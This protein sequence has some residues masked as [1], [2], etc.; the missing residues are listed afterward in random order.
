MVKTQSETP[1]PD[2]APVAPFY[3]RVS[4]IIRD[5]AE[6]SD[7]PQVEINELDGSEI[8]VHDVMFLRGEYERSDPDYAII[9]FGGAT[10]GIA[11][12]R[13]NGHPVPVNARTTSCGGSVF[14]R[15]LKMLSGYG[16]EDAP[17]QL[18]ILGRVVRR[19]SKAA[20]KP[21]PYYDFA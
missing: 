14:V 11:P 3:K 21:Q 7:I 13:L 6:W 1:E 20:G 15:K 12:E 16:D 9:L 5:P 8:V 18:P 2:A 19:Q 17:T 10:D 4:E